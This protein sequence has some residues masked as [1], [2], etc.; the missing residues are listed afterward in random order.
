MSDNLEVN[1]LNHKPVLMLV[2]PI[3]AAYRVPE[4]EEMAKDWLI[5][6]YAD[7]P[8]AKQGFG[9]LALDKE[10]FRSITATPTYSLLNGKLNYQSGLLKGLLHKKPDAIFITANIRSISYWLI[11]IAAFLYRIP[12]YS[13]GQGLYRKTSLNFFLR[14]MYS[15]IV[16]LST[17]YICY[18]ELSRQS[19]IKHRV[20]F[21]YKIKVAEN[22]L[23]NFYPILPTNKNHEEMG[24]MFIGR[25]RHGSN[26]QLLIEVLDE[27]RGEYPNLS[28]HVLGNGTEYKKLE[29]KQQHNDWIKLYG[30]VYDQ[31]KIAEISKHCFVGCYPGDAGLSVVHYMSMSLVPIV[32][33]SLHFHMGPEPSYVINKQ[34]GICFQRNNAKETLSIA[35]KYLLSNR[36][37]VRRLSEAAFNSYIRLTEPPLGMRF[38]NILKQQH[39]ALA[40]EQT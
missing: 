15:L 36:S 21:S 39:S 1:P 35:L 24:V 4:F 17:A 5:D 9:S 30:S 31:Q 32:H 13:H 18:S 37:E 8:D 7:I 19:M 11:L 40:R 6:V 20:A 25:L 23:R 34:N 16:G 14:A 3:I 29:D 27:L 38:S 12:L 22:S 33:D 26:I 28:L 10:K 2:Q